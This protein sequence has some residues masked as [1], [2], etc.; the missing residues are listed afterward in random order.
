[1]A[2]RPWVDSPQ[3]PALT[4]SVVET[5]EFPEEDETSGDILVGFL[6]P[7][8]NDPVATGALNVLLTYLAG[9][10]VSAL[11]NIM[12]E[13]EE[14]ASSVTYWWDARPSTVIWFQPTSVATDKLADVEKRL[15]EIL[16]DVA[17][18]P[19]DMSYL[20]DCL[21]R[22]KRTI[23][24]QAESSGNF[25]ANNIIQDF[26]FGKRDG[27]T[28]TDMA[29]I[30]EFDVLGT[31]TDKQWRD[32]MKKWISDA[33]HVSILGVPSK[34]LSDKM[35]ADEIARVNAQKEKLGKEGLEKL[36]KKLE[37]A[38]AKN[39]AEIPQ[40]LLEKWPV[41]GV[42][43][44]HF[45]ESV[46][47]RSGLAKRLGTSESYAQKIADADAA[48]SPLFV[49][50][51]HVP[52]NFVHIT[53]LMGSSQIPVEQ[54]P[55]LPLFI[56][57]FFN[58]PIM[59]DGQRMEFEQVVTELE[60]DT[61]NYGMRGASGLSDGESVAMNFVIEPEKYEKA[62]HWVRSLMFDAIF[63]ETRL[64]A[65]VTKIL[66]DIPDA[67]RSGN[68]MAYGVDSMIHLAS[69]SIS[70]ARST[71]V[72]AT[73]MKRIKKIMEN[74]PKVVISW[75]DTIRKSLFT[76]ENFRVLVIADIKQLKNP[77]SSWKI[78]TE[79]LDTSKDILPFQKQ[80][81]RLSKAGQ[82][83]GE[84]GAYVIPMPT[85]D[86]SFLLAT[87]DG[88]T[89]FTDPRMPALMVAVSYLDAVEGPLWAAV[90]GTG[91][92]YGT[93]FS[94]DIDAGFLQ[95]RVYRSPDAYKAFA[96]S[97]AIIESYIVGATK[98]EN[99]ALEGA[100]SGIVVA[101]ADEQPTM[102]SAAQMNFVN[103]VVRDVGSDYNKQIMEKV[104]AVSV[105]EIKAAMKDTLLPA[106][107]PGKANIVV[108]CAPIMEE[109]SSLPFGG[110]EYAN[111][112]FRVSRRVLRN[113]DSRLKSSLCLIS[114][115]IMDLKQTATR[116]MRRVRMKRCLM[117]LE[118]SLMSLSIKFC[119]V[120]RDNFGYCLFW[121]Y[122]STPLALDSVQESRDQSKTQ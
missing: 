91:L 56:D 108:T 84:L 58:T 33:H 80:Y 65:A 72:K 75:L 105:D 1:M 12:V 49:Q 76:F 122:T 46:T 18:K 20:T 16:K 38:K 21:E 98:F 29:S 64:K 86:S 109:V 85:I 60:K 71:L 100:I 97:K 81:T 36:A 83:P 19:L 121:L 120:V 3:T 11:E 116:P 48:E 27:S 112:R 55:L 50:F 95:F 52:T 25:F 79:G 110:V 89:S 101:M 26:L 115:R 92:A 44:I 5:V 119:E 9:S 30:K 74:D 68:S 14:L 117:D 40:S 8:C 63:D 24:F 104:R 61:I 87:A 23:K 73:Y 39:D 62:I 17:S 41:P 94:R 82:N 53:L 88:P 4:E 13:K 15:F 32:F 42:E 10:S 2:S 70:K 69:E 47:A 111:F 66:A 118:M 99:H 59:Y 51:E 28:L 7:D 57:N 35:K 106:F 113:Q 43:S 54:R 90:R 6:G 34:K 78:L 77:V 31:W 45:I 103:T 37:D 22:E 114:R 93:G 96:A 102:S 107:L 67:K